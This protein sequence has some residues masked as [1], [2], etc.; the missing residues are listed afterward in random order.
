VVVVNRRKACAVC[1]IIVET[2][3]RRRAHAR[4]LKGA[5]DLA[6]DSGIDGRQLANEV[7]FED[8]ERYTIAVHQ[9]VTP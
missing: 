9:T 7:P 8:S 4:T 3:H 6:G 1:A 2:L 5:G